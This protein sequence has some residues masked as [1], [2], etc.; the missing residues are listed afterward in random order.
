MLGFG[1]TAASNVVVTY[2]VDAYRPVCLTLSPLLFKRVCVLI[3]DKDIRRSFGD[4][5]CCEE[6]HGVRVELVYCGL[7]SSRRCE[8]CVW[9]DGWHSVRNFVVV[10]CSLFLGEED[11]S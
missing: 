1:L 3:L 10:D 7:D 6:C 5:V 9:G 8:E 4:R 2:A 11:K